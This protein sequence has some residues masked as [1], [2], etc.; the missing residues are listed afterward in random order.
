MSRGETV[1]HPL[2][3]RLYAKQS[4]AAESRGVADQRGR[5]L[6]GLAGE[7]VEIGAGN[8]LNFLHYPPAVTLVHAFEPDPYLRGLAAQAADDA[9][10]PVK[11]GEA[12]AEDLP[13]EDASVDAAVASLVLCSVGDPGRAIAELHR[14]V[15]PGG[16]LRFN[17]HVVSQHSLR[18]A[19]Q[20]AM[21]ALMGPT[22]PSQWG[23]FTLTQPCN[24]PLMRQ[25]GRRCPVAAIWG[26]K[27]R[28]P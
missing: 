1:S 28:L 23:R 25:C 17:E 7:V 4:E 8:G 20:L 12:V 6:A 9:A 10:V 21:S 15:R 14:V 16:E 2:C 13:L 22:V 27:P 5:M 3:A 11:V 18:R 26:A 19:L 24:G